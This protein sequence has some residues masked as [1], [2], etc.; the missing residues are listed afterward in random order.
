[1]EFA[2][3]FFPLFTTAPVGGRRLNDFLCAIGYFSAL[4]IVVVWNFFG[5]LSFVFLL[6]A[7]D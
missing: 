3:L 6:R 4:L 1:M 5:F 7:R 2:L